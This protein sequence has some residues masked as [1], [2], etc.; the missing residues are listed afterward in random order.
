MT[1][2]LPKQITIKIESQYGVNVAR[3]ICHA[4][5]VF[6]DIAGTKTLTKQTLEHV[7]LLGYNVK[8]MQETKTLVDIS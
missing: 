3:P 1:K 5:Q 7:K 2:T 4:A 6:A 8:I